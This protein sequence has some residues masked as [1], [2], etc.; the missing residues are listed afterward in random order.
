[1]KTSVFTLILC[2]VFSLAHADKLVISETKSSKEKRFDP[3]SEVKT[4]YIQLLKENAEIKKE[5]NLL[6]SRT[7]NWGDVH[8]GAAEPQIV[9]WYPWRD[10]WNAG[11]GFDLD[12]RYLVVQAIDFGVPKWY[13]HDSAIVSEFRVLHEGTTY[14][15]PNDQNE[16][17]RLI[18]NKITIEFL[19]FRNFTLAPAQPLK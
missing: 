7:E 6:A 15:D 11:E 18:M 17:E 2:F 12:E 3:A 19:G 1:M 4:Y 8:S 13:E 5:F 16:K 14:I 9:A 10:K